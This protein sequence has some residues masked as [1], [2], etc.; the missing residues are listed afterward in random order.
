M[1]TSLCEHEF[2]R[3]GADRKQRSL[4]HPTFIGTHLFYRKDGVHL[5]IEDRRGRGVSGGRGGRGPILSHVENQMDENYKMKISVLE[6][7]D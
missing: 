6:F 3:T 1:S 4:L 5:F 2:D 7:L